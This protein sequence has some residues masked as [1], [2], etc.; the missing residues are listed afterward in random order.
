MTASR[1]PPRAPA[2]S[3]ATAASPS[4]T[5]PTTSPDAVNLD[6]TAKATAQSVESDG[7]LQTFS[8]ETWVRTRST[9]AGAIIGYSNNIGNYDRLLCMDGDGHLLLGLYPGAYRILT[10]AGSYNDGQWHHVVA[11]LGAAGEI[12]Y[13]DGQQVAADTT[14]TSAQAMG[15]YW[16]LGVGSLGWPGA[17]SGAT[18]LNADVD[19][20]AVYPTQL[21]ADAVARHHDLG[22]DE[23]PSASFTAS[24]HY[25]DATLDA[26]ASTA[27]GDGTTASYAWDFG[28][29]TTG[30]GETA[31]HAYATPGTY[32]VTLTVTDALGATST[33]TSDVVVTAPPLATDSFERTATAGW[34]DAEIGGAWT[35]SPASRFSVADGAGVIAMDKA[36]STSS[37]SFAGVSSTSTT[38]DA[39]YT[40]TETLT[41]GGAYTTVNARQTAAGS[42]GVKVRATSSGTLLVSLVRKVG[43]TETSLGSTSVKGW[44]AGEPIHV[45]VTADGTGTT[46]LA[47]SVWLGDT[48]PDVAMLTATDSTEGLQVAGAVGVTEYLS[49]GAAST[50]GVMRLDGLTATTAD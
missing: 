26:S 4:P 31:E 44:T 6:G 43:A 48:A 27:H 36:G 40:Y 35:V 15:G 32:T 24:E 18:V 17:P 45:S 14:T 9:A 11:T 1:P 12:L 50:T 34:G 19:E 38:V 5:A 30:T 16:T 3:S 10:T 33:T 49:A 41:G 8:L 46:N 29:G 7:D 28:D 39:D 22:L 42:Y 25:L 23:P 21:D 47:A 2:S 37:A 20:T 13:V